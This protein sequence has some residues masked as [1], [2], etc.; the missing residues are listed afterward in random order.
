MRTSQDAAH[1]SFFFL[2][3]SA[4]MNL[5][6]IKEKKVFEAKYSDQ[7]PQHGQ[8]ALTDIEGKKDGCVGWEI[9]G[10]MGDELRQR[11]MPCF[12]LAYVDQCSLIK[13]SPQDEP[14]P[15]ARGATT[16]SLKPQISW[17]ISVQ[18]CRSQCFRSCG[19]VD[20]KICPLDSEN[21]LREGYSR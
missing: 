7:F 19:D 15:S 20:V 8:W 14:G 11:L 6:Q 5:W 1:P 16:I 2:L 18:A 9:S 13:I 10:S 3:S 12:L 21:K 4:L 17:I